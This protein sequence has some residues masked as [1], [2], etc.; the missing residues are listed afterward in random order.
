MLHLNYRMRN[1][2]VIP[3][4]CEPS[5]LLVIRKNVK[6]FGGVEDDLKR[7][8]E[9][10]RKSASS[11][12]SPGAGLLTADEQAEAAFGDLINTSM[13][14][15]GISELSD[16]DAELLS[17]GGKMW[18]TGSTSQSRSWGVFGDLKNLVNALSGGAHIDNLESKK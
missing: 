5:K 4:T 10:A 2:V 1:A 11:S 12:L 7:A 13:D 3:S 17:R 16:E 15:R 14:Q 8:M 6:V 9:N 18:E